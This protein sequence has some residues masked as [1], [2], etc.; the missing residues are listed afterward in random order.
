MELKSFF[1]NVALLKI[2]SEGDAYA[3]EIIELIKQLTNNTITP[4][5]GTIYPALYRLEEEGF[6]SSYKIKVGKRMERVYYHIKDTG[7][8]E[9][10]SLTNAFNN[11]IQYKRNKVEK[12]SSFKCIK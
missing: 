11:I 12:D 2:L 1:T 7:R 3:Y 4:I 6:I 8:E 9:L 5:P 10:E